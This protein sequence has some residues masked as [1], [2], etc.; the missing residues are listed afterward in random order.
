[1]FIFYL[2]IPGGQAFAEGPTSITV[3]GSL[4]PSTGENWSSVNDSLSA[5]RMDLGQKQKLRK[6]QHSVLF[7]ET[8]LCG[9]TSVILELFLCFLCLDSLFIL[10]SEH[11]RDLCRRW[12]KLLSHEQFYAITMLLLQLYRQ[13]SEISVNVLIYFASQILTSSA[14]TKIQVNFQKIYTVLRHTPATLEVPTFHHE[15]NHVLMQCEGL[16]L[17]TLVTVLICVWK[18][19]M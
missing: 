2:H 6:F 9:T 5:G 10:P 13:K 16:Y 7:Y 14:A 1:M 3:T 17:H 19:D 4:H 8:V 12:F 18:W 11:S 15:N